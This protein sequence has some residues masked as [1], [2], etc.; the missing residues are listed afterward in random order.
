MG[1]PFLACESVVLHSQK[2]L[3]RIVKKTVCSRMIV[4][5]AS[6]MCLEVEVDHTLNMTSIK[7][8]YT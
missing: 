4:A 3:L 6:L 1:K 7:G 5:F 8:A 2:A